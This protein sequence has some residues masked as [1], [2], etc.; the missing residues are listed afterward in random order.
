MQADDFMP[1]D[2]EIA[3]IGKDIEAY[4]AERS[5]ASRSVRWRL[6][7]YL[8]G[9]AT[10]IFLLAVAFNL[11]ADPNETWL[12]PPHVFLYF[13]G[14]AGAILLWRHATKPARD[15]QQAFR[16]KV[17]PTIFGFIEDLRYR[18]GVAP[19]TFDRLPREAVG[20]F[21]RK[22]FD[23]VISG[24][25]EDFAFELYEARLSRKAGKSRNTV[26]RGVVLTF[27]MEQVFPG[28]LLATRRA[29][30][31]GRLFRDLFG[32]GGLEE[33]KSGVESLD[34]IYDFRSDN[35]AAARPLVTGRLARALQ[36]LGEAW[37]EAPARVALAGKD[38]FLL[39]PLTKDFFEL[40]DI[41]TPVSYETHLRTIIA[42]MAS[43]LATGALVRKV[44]GAGDAPDTAA[45]V[46]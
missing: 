44:G 14:A 33:L 15:I 27:E 12:S 28:L 30:A 21:N 31:V 41:D 32:G 19:D 6:V 46:G 25:Y 3:R 22:R 38:G 40:P 45:T 11:F 18:N 8:G 1:S 7:G 16:D 5:V 35:A 26:F 13:A 29:N 24:R 43:L 2:A 10:A 9:L 20:P 17:L 4:E 34:A 39:L 37:P 42:D 36:W 23:D